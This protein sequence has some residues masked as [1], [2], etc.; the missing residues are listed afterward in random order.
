M[1]KYSLILRHD[2]T[3]REKG[4]LLWDIKKTF[5]TE[6]LKIF[7]IYIFYILWSNIEVMKS[8]GLIAIIS[9]I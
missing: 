4:V 8:D 2:P 3:L 5:V 1:S 9:S 6:N 7:F